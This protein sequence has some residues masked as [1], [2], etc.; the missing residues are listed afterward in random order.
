MTAWIETSRGVVKPWECDIV[1]HF[2]VAY[3]FDRFGDATLALMD[4][5][6]VGPAHIKSTRRACA[7][8]ACDVSYQRELRVGSRCSPF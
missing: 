1:E 6:G 8:V 5:F 2:T 3:Y 4:A 7:T